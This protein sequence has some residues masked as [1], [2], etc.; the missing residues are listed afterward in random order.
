MKTLLQVFKRFFPAKSEALK[1]LIAGNHFVAVRAPPDGEDT[2]ASLVV[3][4]DR[5]VVRQLLATW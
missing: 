4:A 1:H 2:D 5:A 3:P